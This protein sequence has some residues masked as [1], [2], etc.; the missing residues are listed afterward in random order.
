MTTSAAHQQVLDFLTAGDYYSAHQKAR[1]TATR[2]LAPPRRAA[3]PSSSTATLPYDKKAQEAAQGLWD[4]SRRLLEQGQVGSGVDLAV[5]LIEEVYKAREVGCG[6]DERDKI[7]QL[8]ALTGP[9]GAWRKTLTD[10][11]FSWTAK[12][13]SGPAGDV[14][15]HQ[16]LGETLH[17]ELNYHQA[18]LHLLVC[19]TQSAARTLADVLFDWSKLDE[20]GQTAVGRYAARGTL[21]YLESTFI[22]AARTF[23]S[24]FL[25]LALAAYPSLLVVQYPYPPPNSPLANSPSPPASDELLMTKLASLNFLQLAV[26]AAQAGVGE[27]VEKQKAPNGEMRAVRGQTTRVWQ[28]LVTRYE[29]Q[30][31]W[32]KQGELKESIAALGEIYFGIKPARQG[33]PLMDM[34]ANMFGGGGGGGGGGLP[35]LGSR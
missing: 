30:V 25:S 29:K 33:N 4:A 31:P 21:S 9:A 15:I 5:M 19:P 16:Y 35:A 18:T 24:H 23:L 32:L 3:P 26:R 28:G 8:I 2:L 34:M 14:E 7:I 13:G 22:L 17:K 20:E 27:A 12:T 1:T 10:A 11:V 6:K